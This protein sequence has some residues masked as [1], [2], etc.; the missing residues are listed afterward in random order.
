M[1]LQKLQF[2]PGINKEGTSYSNEGGWFDGDKIRFRSGYVE[3]IGG[4]VQ[5][6]GLPFD[7]QA[8]K[9]FDFVTLDDLSYLFIGTNAKVYLEEGS[10][11]NDITPIRRSVLLPFTLPEGIESETSV[12]D[13]TILTP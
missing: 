13:V 1:A 9:L 11:L 8:R 7:G 5:V 12:G 4:W 3:R 10:V 2:R 6:N